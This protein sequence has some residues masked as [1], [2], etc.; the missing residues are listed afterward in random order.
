MQY[1]NGTEF[2][3]LCHS[4]Y[5]LYAIW[6]LVEKMKGNYIF[7]AYCAISSGD[8]SAITLMIFSVS[9]AQSDSTC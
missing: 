2:I 9:F 5:V 4:F 6:L 1:K 7:E 3:A 8:A